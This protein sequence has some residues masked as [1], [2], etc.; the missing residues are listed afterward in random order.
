MDLVRRSK[1][2]HMRLAC[3]TCRTR[4]YSEELNYVNNVRAQSGVVS[5]ADYVRMGKYGDDSFLEDVI[6]DSKEQF[7]FER[8]VTVIGS[9]GTKIESVVRRLKWLVSQNESVKCL[10]FSEWDD[11]LGVVE[12]AIQTNKINSIRGA[13]GMKFGDAVERFLGHGQLRRRVLRAPLQLLR[14]RRLRRRD[15]RDVQS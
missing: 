8:S 12:K 11:V 1:T 15:G 4:A 10:V 5:L 9:W 7:N 13:S 6:G 2:Q 3:V 14:E